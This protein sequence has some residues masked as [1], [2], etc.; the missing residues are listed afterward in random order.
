MVL[1]VCLCYGFH[2]GVVIFGWVISLCKLME[3]RRKIEAAL[4]GT[5]YCSNVLEWERGE[6]IRSHYSLTGTLCSSHTNLWQVYSMCLSFTTSCL[7][8]VYSTF[9]SPISL[10][11]F[12]NW[13]KCH[14]INQCLLS[15][16]AE[17][18]QS[19]YQY[20]T[21]YLHMSIK[22]MLIILHFVILTSLWAF[23]GVNNC[24]THLCLF[25]C[26]VLSLTYYT[27]S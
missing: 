12:K 5:N 16:P 19:L 6:E 15:N 27:S 26:P 7:H 18:S 3:V 4:W 24:L 13:F 14:I 9:N 23:S 25:Y 8:N 10:S 20:S 11:I 1:Y 2:S 17:I 22:I 21:V